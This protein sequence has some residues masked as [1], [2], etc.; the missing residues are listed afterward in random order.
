MFLRKLDYLKQIQS[1]NL[2]QVIENI[3]QVRK[4]TELAA[5]AELTSYLSQRYIISE[6]F[7]DTDVYSNSTT[8]KAKN[9]VEYTETAWSNA[10][11]YLIGNRVSY[12][13]KIYQALTNN[14]NKQPDT[15]LSD[16]SY[17]VDDQLL[18][19]VTLPN[20]EWNYK[21]KYSA[22]SI[23]WYKDSVY[24]A[25]V[26]NENVAPDSSLATWGAGTPYSVLAGTKPTDVSKWTKGDNRNQQIVLYMV[27]VTLYHLHSRINP[28]NI[29]Q[30]RGLRYE[31]AIKWLKMVASGDITADLKEINPEQGVSI[32][33][34]SQTKNVNFY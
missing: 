9:L 14:T 17:V 34:G 5:Q 24:T 33:Y 19:Y 27:D 31:E 26:E 15:N 20:N 3:D 8:Y 12:S 32:R 6:T 1:D 11:A 16:W 18:F 4:D 25:V 29:P 10:T 21:T 28:R 2:N 13:G 23:V 7:R 22:G 30:L